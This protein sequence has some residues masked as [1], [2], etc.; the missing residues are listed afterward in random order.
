MRQNNFICFLIG[1]CLWA[2]APTD[3]DGET[4][5]VD[6]ENRVQKSIRF[7][8]FVDSITYAT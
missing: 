3:K 2:C 4:K 6:L 7:Y 1:I 8:S 5:I